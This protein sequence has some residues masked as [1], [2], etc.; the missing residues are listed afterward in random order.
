M[1]GMP[2]AGLREAFAEFIAAS[3]RLELS[4]RELQGEVGGLSRELAA[5]NAALKESLKENGAMRRG[6]EQAVE[7]MPCGVLVVEADGAVAL[8]NAEAGRLLGL[9]RERMGSVREIRRR[10]GVDVLGGG[11]VLEDGGEQELVVRGRGGDEA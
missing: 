10:C 9:G 1:D 8:R 7:S 4:Y 2:A 5:R 6:L 3:A 11:A